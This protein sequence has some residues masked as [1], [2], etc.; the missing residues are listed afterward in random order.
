MKS[1]W[2][3]A[4]LL[5]GICL[6]ACGAKSLHS[7]PS[8][9]VAGPQG[10]EQLD[11][12]TQGIGRLVADLK[13]TLLNKQGST[14][15]QLASGKILVICLTSA[16]C[17]I[18]QKYLETYRR[19]IK[20]WSNKGVQFLFVNPME[21]ESA[22]EIKAQMARLSA[23]YALDPKHTLAQSIGATTTTEVFVLDPKRTLVYRGAVDDQYGFG[24]TRPNPSRQFLDDAISATLRGQVPEI[25]AT[26]APGCALNF[27][28][29]QSEPPQITYHNRISRIIQSNCMTCHRTNGV[30]PFPLETYAQVKDKA[31]MIKF[32]TESKR[33]PPWFAAPE[34]GHAESKW[35]NDRS[36]TESDL[37]ALQTW[38]KSGMPEG[39][40]ADAPA[41]RTWPKEW[42]IGIPSQIVSL[43]NAIPVKADGVMDYVNVVVDPGLNEDKW[44]KA[45][46]IIPTAKQVV[47]HVLVFI[48]PKGSN[49]S[50]DNGGL[51]GF[52]AG[53]VPGNDQQIYPIGMGKN[54]P[55]GSRFHFQIHYTP[56]GTATQDQMKMGLVYADKP[57]TT[58]IH[59]GAVTSLLLT[60]PPRA[61]N[62]KVVARLPVPMDV[63]VY[64]FLPHMHVRG[65]AYRYEI[66]KPGGERELLLDIPR[67]DFNWQ[68]E[69]KLRKPVTVEKGTRIIG[70]AW[71]DNS[72]KNP[73]NPDPNRR[74]GWGEQTSDEMMLGYL[75]Y[76]VRDPKDEQRLNA[77]GRGR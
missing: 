16:T 52:F 5:G 70:T 57:P 58:E 1:T 77:L 53:Y 60:I 31:A 20:Q 9:V 63:V 64:S 41:P 45:I 38:V 6:V 36:L 21:S 33:M 26:S 15:S 72:D 3:G 61:E 40:T 74:V 8:T 34:K 30:G 46:Q 28:V 32:V 44:V 39:N 19:I 69:Y 24:Y 17:P 14:L 7:G 47:H 25:Q 73:A 56:N 23:P 51:T 62:H 59:T 67:Y 55:A 42:T 48:I 13:I 43:P 2:F 4:A 10:P 71:Y 22:P 18:S 65:K 29:V 68:L 12:R 27:P 49:W 50:S 75:T 35:Q 11:A 54:L 76:S 37:Q 66:E